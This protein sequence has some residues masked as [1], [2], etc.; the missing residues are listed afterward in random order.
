MALINELKANFPPDNPGFAGVPLKGYHFFYNFAGVDIRPR[1]DFI[2]K[3][4]L[5]NDTFP[6]DSLQYSSLQKEVRQGLKENKIS[7]I[8]APQ[9]LSFAK[10]VK[11][12]NKVYENHAAIIYKMDVKQ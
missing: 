3:I 11:Y 2:R 10:D 5:L 8:Y 6:N 7:F 9:P 4:I 1:I 12:L